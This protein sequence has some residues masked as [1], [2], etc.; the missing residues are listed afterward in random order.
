MTCREKGLTCEGLTARKRPKRSQDPQSGGSSLAAD[1]RSPLV[2]STSRTTGLPSRTVP[3]DSDSAN[4]A[5]LRPTDRLFKINTDSSHDSGYASNMSWGDEQARSATSLYGE[6][7][8]F[9]Q[10]PLVMNEDSAPVSPFTYPDWTAQSMQT[11]TDS[12]NLS[13]SEPFSA[14]SA[15]SLI[16]AANVLEKQAMSLRRLAKRRSSRTGDD[17]RRQTI[18]FPLQSNV[19]ASS[20]LPPPHFNNSFDNL[21][22]L[23]FPA[24][25]V[26]ATPF[27]VDHSSCRDMNNDNP[28]VY[29]FQTHGIAPYALDFTTIPPNQERQLL[30]EN[31]AAG[32]FDTY[33]DQSMADCQATAP[34]DVFHTNNWTGFDQG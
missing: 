20:S 27:P 8:R 34:H 16:S 29:G 21:S 25:A 6:D 22:S 2:Y 14:Q 24:L 5:P 12:I 31:V 9:M 19:P 33:E 1:Q 23:G 32:I 18:V 15:T 10:S 30:E 7:G 17:T 26:S 13:T 28:N 3:P 11:P 4:K